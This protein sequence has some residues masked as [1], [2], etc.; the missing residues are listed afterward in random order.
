MLSS[1]NALSMMETPEDYRRRL[2]ENIESGVLERNS[3]GSYRRKLTAEERFKAV[4]NANTAVRYR[5][6]E[7]QDLQ[8]QAAADERS[9]AT[10][11]NV[12]DQ[13]QKA[14]EHAKELER[15][16]ES[17][18]RYWN[19]QEGRRNL[20]AINNA[21]DFGV[22]RI[23]NDQVNRFKIFSGDVLLN[24]KLSPREQFN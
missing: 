13:L 21:S 1:R 19:N 2:F 15:A 24:R 11:K 12:A 3:L 17:T 6:Q 14:A 16:V 10:W 4:E 9:Y 18:V 23:L 22:D 20:A 8:S 5:M 7:F